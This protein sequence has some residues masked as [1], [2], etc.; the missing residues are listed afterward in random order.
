MKDFFKISSHCK[1]GRSVNIG[2][3]T[4]FVASFVGSTSLHGVNKNDLCVFLAAIDEALRQTLLGRGY[5]LRR[6]LSFFA[7]VLFGSS[8]NFFHIKASQIFK[9]QWRSFRN[10]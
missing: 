2:I 1:K 7:V 3:E 9:N 4:G 8:F 10:E 6:G 5:K